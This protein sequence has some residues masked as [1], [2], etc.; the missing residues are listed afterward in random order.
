M[1]ASQLVSEQAQG[2]RPTIANARRFPN[3]TSRRIWRGRSVAIV[4]RQKPTRLLPRRDDGGLNC[5]YAARDF[6]E[7]Q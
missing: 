2:H 6:V 3:K 4:T 7:I 1:A 5:L